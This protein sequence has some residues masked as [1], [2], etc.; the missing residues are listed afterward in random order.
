MDQQHPDQQNSQIAETALTK[1]LLK[2]GLLRTDQV[3]L[4]ASNRDSGLI[5]HLAA[6]GVFEET[7]AIDKIAK[8]LGV[9]YVRLDWDKQRN[10]GALLESELL[11]HIDLATWQHFR[12]IPVEAKD[13]LVTIA[14]ANPLDVDAIRNLEFRLQKKVE[15]AIAEEKYIVA[16]LNAEHSMKDGLDFASLVKTSGDIKTRHQELTLSESTIAT[17]DLN[18][19]VVVRLV[20]KV[21]TSA[22]QLG[23]SDL[24]IIPEVNRLL[25]RIR[26]DGIMRDLLEAPGNMKDALVA[27]IKVLCGM[28]IAERRLPQDGRLRLKT[29]AGNRDLRI[30]TVPTIHGEDVVARIL[31]ADLG[32]VSLDSIGMDQEMKIRFSKIL[33]GS[34]KVIIVTGPT[35]AGKTSTLYASVLQLRNGTTHIITIEDPIEYRIQGISQIQI[36]PRIDLSFDKALRSILRQDPDVILVGE[37][38]DGETAGT[39]MQV[40]QTGHLVLSTMHTNT[41]SAAIT[42]LRDLGIPAFLIASSLGSVLAQRLV[43]K[44]C[45]QCMVPAS[46]ATKQRWQDLGFSA[47]DLHQAQGC[48]ECLGT[49]YRGRIAIFSLLEVTSEISRAIREGVSEHEIHALA[50]KQNFKTLEESALDLVHNRITS[51]DEI[52]RV[53]GPVDKFDFKNNIIATEQFGASPSTSTHSPL[54]SLEKRK[55]LIVDDDEAIRSTFKALLEFEMFDV[56]LAEDGHQALKAIYDHTPEVII[57]DLMMPNVSGLE[58]VEKLRSDPRTREIPVLML[59]AAA[60]DDNEIKLIKSGADDFVSKTA[61]PDLIVA[62]INRLINR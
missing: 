10:I 52:E 59:T 30:S 61:R 55:V 15:V 17:E 42:R 53:L 6:N 36:N 31:S 22:I 43:R 24:H 5:A 49:G 2:L 46:G 56:H 26:V 39:A 3:T 50:K 60:T 32:Q 40:A 7:I 48:N 18:A 23:A 37:I 13:E 14:V 47:E 44:L 19:P 57:C 20:N 41:A 25:V 8:H 28:D 1:L 45:T 11:R 16:A 29:A 4:A 27:R 38:R 21:I 33:S 9:P 12:A 54:V 34:S 51:L 62:R 58:L 35:G